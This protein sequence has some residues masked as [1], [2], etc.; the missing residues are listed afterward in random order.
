MFGNDQLVQIVAHFSFEEAPWSD[1]FL[2]DV[3]TDMGVHST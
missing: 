2:K 1:Y 3:G